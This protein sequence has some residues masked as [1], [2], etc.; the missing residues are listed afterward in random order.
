MQIEEILMRISQKP[1][2]PI[3]LIIDNDKTNGLITLNVGN[4]FKKEIDNPEDVV[5]TIF[6]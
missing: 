1:Y 6:S 4:E 2:R 3:F 5:E